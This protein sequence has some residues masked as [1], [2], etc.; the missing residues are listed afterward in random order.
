MQRVSTTALS[1]TNHAK[2]GMTPIQIFLSGNLIK[3]LPAELFRVENL[4]V[5]ALRK[6]SVYFP[7]A[8]LIKF[9]RQ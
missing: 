7:V 8:A 4:T 2:S 9:Y 3:T 5:L 1:I 6:Y